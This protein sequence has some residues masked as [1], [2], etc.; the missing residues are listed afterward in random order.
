MFV[1]AGTTNPAQPT[2]LPLTA[3]EIT[4]SAAVFNG[5]V[6]PSGENTIAA[7]EYGYS[8]GSYYSDPV[9]PAVE[10]TDEVSLGAGTA[11]KEI[12]APVSDLA[13]GTHVVFRLFAR[14]ARGEGRTLWSGFTTAAGLPTARTGPISSILDT[15]AVVSARIS[16]GNLGATYFFEYSPNVDLMDAISTP[17]QPLSAGTFMGS[18]KAQITDLVP[19]T[20]YYFRAVV[21]NSAGVARS[22]TGSFSLT[23]PS[24]KR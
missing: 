4:N 21:S 20:R 11:W 17:S 16:S 8:E 10:I 3:T 15:S 19:R 12:A 14:N 5:R 7:F 18:V 13:P 22:D 1:T 9:P 2:V 23:E 24:L 6:N